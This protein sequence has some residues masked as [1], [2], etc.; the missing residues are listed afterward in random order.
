MRQ[1]LYHRLGRLEI[2]HARFRSLRDCHDRQAAL[3]GALTKI[4][5]FLRI[6]GVVQGEIESQL[7]RLMLVG[8]DP[9]HKY[10]V[11]QG[12]FEAI[13]ARRA[14]GTWPSVTLLSESMVGASKFG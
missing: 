7:D 8:I 2:E 12:V 10:F 14:A 1:R 3:D 9:I 5:L 11:E 4:D 6:R 13:E